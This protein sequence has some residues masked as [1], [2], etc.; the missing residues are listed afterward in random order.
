MENF[1]IVTEDK[2]IAGKI[3]FGMMRK[4]VSQINVIIVYCRM[5]HLQ[6]L[7]CN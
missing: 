6:T 4:I 5:L 1:A 2:M 7:G 3:T